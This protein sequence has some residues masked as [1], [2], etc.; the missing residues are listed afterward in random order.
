MTMYYYEIWMEDRFGE[1]GVW[2]RDTKEEADTLMRML[3]FG[4]LSPNP[5]K[6]KIVE[7]EKICKIE[8]VEFV[9]ED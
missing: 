4:L 3:S 2:Q 9:M 7:I 1:C 6:F 5:V 8:E